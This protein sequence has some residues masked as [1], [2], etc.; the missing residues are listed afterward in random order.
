MVILTLSE[1]QWEWHDGE[2]PSFSKPGF[3]FSKI[4]SNNSW[5]PF[6]SFSSPLSIMPGVTHPSFP[7]SLHQEGMII[8][9]PSLESSPLQPGAAT[10]AAHHI[11]DPNVN[12][13]GII[14]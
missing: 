14:G 12:Q 3:Y 13:P 2:I 1:E 7:P 10:D 8:K 6:P 5:K 9:S 11:I 4:P